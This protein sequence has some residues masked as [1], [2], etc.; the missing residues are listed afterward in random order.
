MTKILNVDANNPIKEIKYV[1][2][3]G[4]FRLIAFEDK[5]LNTILNSGWG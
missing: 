2:F 5:R 4:K 3:L 1:Q